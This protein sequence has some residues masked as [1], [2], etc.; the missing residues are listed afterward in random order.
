MKIVKIL[1]IVVGIVVIAVGGLLAYI[2]TLDPRELAQQAAGEVREATG[3][4]FDINGDVSLSVSL[5]PTL[6][7][8][9]VA[10]GNAEWGSAPTMASI[11]KLE[12]EIALLPLVSGQVDI[13]RLI[14][15][16]PN[17]LLERQADGTANWEIGDAQKADSTGSA[18]SD[19][20]GSGSDSLP[21]VR[22]VSIRDGQITIKDAVTPIDETITIS[23]LSM[24]QASGSKI[25]LVL[26]AAIGSETL[27]VEGQIGDLS[28][29]VAQNPF[30][31]DLDL[32][33]G[34][35]T[36][37]L[38]GS[39]T[40]ADQPGYAGSVSLDT[41]SL[42]AFNAAA[43]LAGQELPDLGPIAVRADISAQGD[44]AK[45]TNLDASV[46]GVTAKGSVDADQSGS[47]PQ[48][49]IDLVVAA[50]TLAVL[51]QLAEVALPE[52][53]PFEI[54]VSADAS[55]SLVDAQSITVKLAE[56]Q[57]SGSLKADQRGA[58]PNVTLVLTG[59]SL[60]LEPFMAAEGDSDGAAA[61]APA[62]PDGKVI[63]KDPLPLD[64]LKA[65][66][67]T[68]SLKLGLLKLGGPEFKNIDVG[69][70]LK[71]GDLTISPLKADGY[72]GTV[73]GDLAL[74]TS[75]ATP[76]LKTKGTFTDIDLGGL[77][78]DEGI[79]DLVVATLGGAWNLAG[80][81]DNPRA[82]A[83]TLNGETRIEMVDGTVRSGFVDFIAA[84]VMSTATKVF[85]GEEQT[86]LNCFYNQFKITDG[87]ANAHVLLF[88]TDRSTIAGAGEISLKD[89]KLGMKISPSPKQESLV[90]LALPI[91]VEGTF[92][93]P[94]VYP[95][96][97]AVA[98]G[99][100]GIAAGIATGGLSGVL[101]PFVSTGSG[102]GSCEQALAVMNGAP[103]PE[104][105]S[106]GGVGG[107][108]DKITGGGS[109]AGDGAATQGDGTTEGSGGVPAVED[110]VKGLK[111]LF[112]Q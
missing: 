39:L 70:V 102:D 23:E 19:S 58:R 28:V 1:G 96:P 92:A 33:F 100:A 42:A 67:A 5:Q 30:P 29:L 76:S 34:A 111:G 9:D 43:A 61:P 112:S 109:S 12:V 106:S 83:S 32:A 107:L 66:D 75:G 48:A 25:D 110:A 59:N 87:I 86:P 80:Q 74:A 108:L 35:A 37:G 101:V 88:D 62:D 55:P 2:A 17:I 65:V 26:A 99:A 45:I 91:L 98:A 57:L 41:P 60:D 13:A 38:K 7:V 14:L 51:G 6:V 93:S 52:V 22:A 11:G 53:G 44:T 85:S 104:P 64:G 71:N 82:I 63:P 90:S 69:L 40:L 15:V 73:S 49:T 47:E 18:D 94:S 79:T 95:D 20:S 36:A 54:A 84:D 68:V 16:E 31:L 103:L 27:S 50:E 21:V 8:N 97:T 81:G 46:A 72:G 24:T 105:K 78:A 10:F 56:D 3:R 77:L 4:S 89:E